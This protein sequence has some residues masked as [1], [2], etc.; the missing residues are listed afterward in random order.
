MRGLT[1]SRDGADPVETPIACS[2][3]VFL[4]GLP[5]NPSASSRAPYSTLKYRV[6]PKLCASAA[7]AFQTLPSRGGCDSVREKLLARPPLK[8]SIELKVKEPSPFEKPSWRRP[9]S[10]P[11]SNPL[12][13]CFRPPAF[14]SVWF[15]A[16]AVHLDSSVGRKEPPPSSNDVTSVP[17]SRLSERTRMVA[18][19]SDWYGD[20]LVRTPLM[21][22]RVS[23]RVRR[24]GPTYAPSVSC[25]PSVRSRRSLAADGAVSGPNPSAPSRVVPR[26][27]VRARVLRVSRVSSSRPSHVTVLCV[28]FVGTPDATSGMPSGV[29]S[30][31]SRATESGAT[32]ALR[33]AFASAFS[34]VDGSLSERPRS[35]ATL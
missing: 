19:G 6:D 29:A 32:P 11:H 23:L 15:P 30:A 28:R 12:N 1:C 24:P 5:T 10:R 35:S 4:A 25:A 33:S 7:A 27:V 9:S 31:I 22:M 13:R 26:Y 18:P 17:A 2:S 34:S 8:S 20:T 16:S 21:A 14:H 3:A